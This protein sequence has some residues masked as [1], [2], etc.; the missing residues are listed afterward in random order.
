[1]WSGEPRFSFMYSSE[2]NLNPT[3]FWDGFLDCPSL[4]HMSFLW[5][6]GILSLQDN[7]PV[8][9][10]LSLT[11]SSLEEGTNLECNIYPPK[12]NGKLGPLP[13][14]PPPAKHSKKT[15]LCTTWGKTSCLRLQA[16]HQHCCCHGNQRPSSR[17]CS[18]ESWS[19][20]YCWSPPVPF[21]ASLNLIFSG[22]IIQIKVFAGF[23]Y[24]I[25]VNRFFI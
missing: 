4:H 13:R 1:M 22:I 15:M 16:A 8:L 6:H 21:S 18:M 12:M 17:P 19:S 14:E 2:S 3:S 23:Y 25:L 11:V 7:I 9:G 5:T 10:H 24:H 20:C